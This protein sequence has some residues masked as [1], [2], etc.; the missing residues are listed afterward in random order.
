[1]GRGGGLSSALT[2]TSGS[3]IAQPAKYFGDRNV[4]TQSGGWGKIDTGRE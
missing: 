4:V 1:M 3:S 2:P